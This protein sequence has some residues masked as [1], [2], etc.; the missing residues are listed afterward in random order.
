MRLPPSQLLPTLQAS[1]S[2][3]AQ[4]FGSNRDGPLN[5]SSHMAL[6]VLC[7]P[8]RALVCSQDR[9]PLIE[10]SLRVN[11]QVVELLQALSQASLCAT[12]TCGWSHPM[13][14]AGGHVWWA[15]Q[16][17][18][19]N[20]CWDTIRPKQTGRAFLASLQLHHGGHF[21]FAR[22]EALCV[23]VLHKSP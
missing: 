19:A 9:Q 10:L 17:Q 13:E 23:Q 12:L 2:F 15:A 20:H 11:L 14:G 16:G 22:V 4:N 3:S 6:P 1:G 5:R 7:I 21:F 8:N 18:A